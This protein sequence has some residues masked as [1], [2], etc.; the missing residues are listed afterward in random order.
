MNF[1]FSIKP[2]VKIF[3]GQSKVWLLKLKIVY[4]FSVK[5]VSKKLFLNLVCKYVQL[6]CVFLAV[7]SVSTDTIATKNRDKKLTKTRE[8]SWKLVKTRQI[9][10]KRKKSSNMNVL[11]IL[12][13]VGFA[14]ATSMT[15]KERIAWQ[16]K[17][18]KGKYSQ[19]VAKIIL[20][21]FLFRLIH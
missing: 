20:S 5:C 21:R 15:L 16:E 17:D 8:I 7:T 14:A 1:I 4:I 2:Q 18:S 11:T 10:T 9:T 19:I 13:L 6:F 3:S 12:S